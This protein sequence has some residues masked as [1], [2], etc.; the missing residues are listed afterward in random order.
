[1]QDPKFACNA[2]KQP[3]R[4]LER[5]HDDLHMR[6]EEQYSLD[7]DTLRDAHT[8]DLKKN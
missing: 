2:A 6:A 8:A 1:M 4:E 5:T 7:I 3:A